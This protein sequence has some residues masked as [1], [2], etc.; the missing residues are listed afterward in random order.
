LAS[1]IPLLV[2]I[3]GGLVL[4]VAFL[5]ALSVLLRRKMAPDKVTACLPESTSD[6]G[7]VQEAVSIAPIRSFFEPDEDEPSTPLPS[8]SMAP[9]SF[10]RYVEVRG[11]IQGWTEAGLD[12]QA[13][14]AAVFGIEHQTYKEAH[15]WWMLALEDVDDRLRDV[16]R[17]VAVFAER[18]G[19]TIE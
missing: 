16:D 8:E 10:K 1:W 3:V 14:L 4:G 12:V 13:Q 2:G 7:R 5:L 19:S 9:L 11:A 17:Q 15:A 6:P 18:Y